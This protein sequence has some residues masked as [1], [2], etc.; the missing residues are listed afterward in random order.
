VATSAAAFGADA[1]LGFEYV[2]DDLGRITSLT[3]AGAGAYGYRYDD[4]GRLVEVTRDGQTLATYD[5]DANGNR[6]SASGVTAEYDDQDRLVRQGATEYEY[7]PN[8]EVAAVTDTATG[9]T[10]RYRYGA[11][12]ALEG[13]TLPDG[14]RLD[15][16]LDPLGRRVAVKRDGELERG[17]LYGPGGVP[18]AELDGSGAVVSRFVYATRTNVPDW[19]TRDGHTYRILTDHLGSP[20]K[21]VDVGSGEVVQEL[22]YDA[23]GNVLR[24]TRPGFQP[25]GFAGGLYDSD[26]KLTHFGAREYDASTGRW[27]ARDPI[28]F[29]GGD[30]NLYGYV[31]GDP[32]NFVDPSGLAIWDD[33]FDFA[34][35]VAD[36]VGLT[37]QRVVDTAAGFG[38][39]ASGLISGGVEFFTFGQVD[40]PTTRDIR[41]DLGIDD[42]VNHCSFWYKGASIAGGA[43]ATFTPWGIGK[44]IQWGFKAA[45]ALA[46]R[47]LP[48]AGKLLRDLQ[49]LLR[50]ERGSAGGGTW[51]W[52]RYG[53][54]YQRVFY[55][56]FPNLV[57]KLAA[58]HHAIPQA[59]FRNWPHLYD[60]ALKDSLSNLR[61]IPDTAA[62][63]QAHREITNHW[64][65]IIRGWK[66]ADYTPSKAEIEAIV[67]LVDDGWGHHFLP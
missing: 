39:G 20:R 22:E 40:L 25:F 34:A 67:R 63:R 35:G 7:T 66:R 32:V 61:G 30:S 52:K 38:D 45:D 44:G 17:F 10:T 48:N 3:E 47:F 33:A 54:K 37:D 56:A 12:G 16:V 23:Y 19:F 28:G 5:Y 65:T 57:G 18:A 60:D 11:L 53:K 24:D 29:A 1:L 55:K 14:T 41:K 26:T 49:R 59:V 50:S 13:A 62:G 15:Y 31:L 4:A 2:R 8:G 58:I 43:V 36:G 21:I 51:A 9:D 42:V 6:V 27:T 46:K 64:N